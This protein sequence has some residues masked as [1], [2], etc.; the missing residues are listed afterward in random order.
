MF[1]ILLGFAGISMCSIFRALHT[2]LITAGGAPIAPASPAPLIPKGFELQ[3][4]CY[5]NCR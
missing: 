2:A 4:I 5:E 3:S 1:Q